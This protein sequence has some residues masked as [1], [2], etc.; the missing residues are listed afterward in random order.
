MANKSKW[1]VLD[2][3]L[4]DLKHEWILTICLI[5][6]IS[7]VLSPL[8]LLF[9]LKFGIIDWG[10][11]YLAQ[12]P[13]YREIRPLASKSFDKTWFASMHKRPDVAFIIPMTRQIS[14]TVKANIKNRKNKIELNI[15]PTEAGDPLILE[16]G[17]KI[18]EKGECVLT[19]FAAESLGAKKGDVLVAR[20]SRIV[21]SRYEYGSLELK[22]TGILTVRASEL[23]SMYVRLPVLEAVERYKD[24]QAVPEYG[25]PGS[26]PRA[27]PLF[28]GIVIVL[29][30]KLTKF[31]ELS[32]CNKTG[33]T[34]IESLN[35][36]QLRKKAGFRVKDEMAV[37]RLYTL[38][39]PAGI[40]SVRS[41]ENKLR[42]KNA[43]LFLWTA[44]F[45]AKL[46]NPDKKTIA[47]LTAYGLSA[48]SEKAGTVG[49]DPVPS[50]GSDNGR[51]KDILKIM[52]P[53]D[54]KADGD[55]FIVRIERKDGVLEFPV[56]ALKQRTKTPGA[57]F[58]PER[59]AGIIRLYKMR[60]IKFDEK[61]G[62]FILFRRGYASFR[63]YAKSIF[64]VDGLRR[65]FDSV[66]IPVHTE[67]K[68][69]KKVVELDKGMTLIFWLLAIVGIAGSVASLIASLYA[70]VERKK[71]ELSVLRLIGLSGGT[72]FRFPVYQGIIFGSGG[73]AISMILFFIFSRLINTW[74]KPYA[75]KLL[76]FPMEA[77]VSFCRLPLTH[78][79]GALSVT[80]LIAAISAMVAA[81][82][83]TGIEPAEALRD[84]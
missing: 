73:F 27:Y 70:S 69:I 26:T 7:A 8:L 56:E 43:R 83:V 2:L 76:G 66:S 14:A 71:R 58:V 44:P 18:P 22:V 28:D 6:A 57:A 32:L 54:V 78:V 82:R 19:K 40:A 67:I 41:V 33:F 68:E 29:P 1:I 30:K 21:G 50:W 49:L 59:L 62:E 77:G 61:E 11:N 3:S 12:D 72:L 38:H 15:I 75:D 35:T 37:Y 42:G 46:L 36:D 64:Q 16:N 24:G 55:K 17:A 34:K 74:F 20:A 60:N 63:L 13:R 79:I 84:E 53:P 31:Q 45:S 10:R 23:K 65:F 52:L 80:I 48:D 81:F 25:W 4:K 47:E 9:G 39:K 51:A 5:M